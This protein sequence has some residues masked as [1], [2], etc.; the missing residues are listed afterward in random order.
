M[1][2]LPHAIAGFGGLS[3][4]LCFVAGLAGQGFHGWLT[5]GLSIGASVVGALGIKEGGVARPMAIGA[6]VMFLVVAMKTN[7][8]SPNVSNIMVAAFFGMI[9]AIVQAVKPGK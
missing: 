8:G 6:A 5:I 7:G 9:V 1:K 2:Y 3:V 4:I